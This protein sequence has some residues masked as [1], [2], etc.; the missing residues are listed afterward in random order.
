[1]KGANA[2]EHQVKEILEEFGFIQE[3][4]FS[5]WTG[6][7]VRLADRMANTFRNEGKLFAFGTGAS[8][9]IAQIL[10][11][12]L[13]HRIAVNRPPL[14]AIALSCGGPLVGAIAEQASADEIFSR[15]LEGLGRK[16]DL[17]LAFSPDGESPAALRALVLA[18]ESDLDTAAILGRDG[19]RMKNYT[20]LALVVEGD[21]SARIHEV[22]LIAAQILA[23]LVERQL[24]SL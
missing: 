19:G 21:S 6:E 1:V 5:R 12:E 2:I 20:E 16:G 8:G 18:R 10:V 14:P 24:F 15:Q 4:F 23:Q 11:E 13:T 3:R 17:A 22:H 9:H 7:I